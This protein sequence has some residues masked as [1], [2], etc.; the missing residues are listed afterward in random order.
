MNSHGYAHGVIKLQPLV[1]TDEQRARGL[2]INQ[3]TSRP[4]ANAERLGDY[5]AA[6]QPQDSGGEAINKDPVPTLKIRVSKQE[7]VSSRSVEGAAEIRWSGAQV[8]MADGILELSQSTIPNVLIESDQAFHGL[9]QSVNNDANLWHYSTNAALLH[10]LVIRGP[11]TGSTWIHADQHLTLAA[12]S[13]GRLE[14]GIEANLAGMQESQ[15]VDQ[16]G[17]DVLDLGASQQLS[18][19]DGDLAQQENLRISIDTYGMVNSAMVMGPGNNWISIN[20]TLG[21]WQLGLAGLIGLIASNQDWGLRLQAR[22]IAMD[23]SQLDSG[24]GNDQVWVTASL[25]PSIGTQLGTIAT[26][27]RAQIELRQIAARASSLNLGPGDDQ[28]R[29]AGD[30][31]DSSIDLGTG[32]NRLIFDNGAQHTAIVMGDNSINQII[33]GDQANTIDLH[34]GEVLTLT[35]G[36]DED[37][38]YLSK[39]ATSGRIDGGGGDDTIITTGNSNGGGSVLMLDGPNRGKL[40]GFSILNIESIQLGTGDNQVMVS[41]GGWLTGQLIGGAGLDTLDLSADRSPVTL[42]LAPGLISELGKPSMGP[43]QGFERV[44]GGSGNDQFLLS[45]PS[46]NPTGLTGLEIRG[47]P[48]IDQFLWDSLE[49]SW[50]HGMDQSSGLP[51]LA[52]LQISSKPDGGIGLS[53]QIGWTAWSTTDPNMALGSVH[54]LTPSTIDGLGDSQLLPI[55]P[56]EQLL[57]GQA[58][59]GSKGVSQLAIGTTATGAELL[60]LGPQGEHGVIAHLPGFFSGYYGSTP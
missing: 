58:S 16:G 31:I 3:E 45:N 21:P 22:A 2:E 10:A 14:V 18:F 49:P 12:H 23:H 27:P 20:S 44:L 40:D 42:R 43:I 48:G 56:M 41:P 32:T 34:G 54:L 30:V 50:P 11:G 59:L 1:D 13:P 51:S 17:N 26:N 6:N 5:H 46:T 9:V 53:D 37:Q 24:A 19:S 4:L 35:G 39:E 47:G 33:L 55:A 57:A 7:E 52:D 38:I 15:L 25:D 60:A 29:L 36:P 28:L 8:G